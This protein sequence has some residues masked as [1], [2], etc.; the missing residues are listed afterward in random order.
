VGGA[1]WNVARA[2]STLGVPAAFAGAVSQ[3]DLGDELATSTEQAG[4]DLRF[5]QR[6]A[7]PPFLAL[8]PSLHP[9]RYFF[10]GGDSADLAFEPERL[11]EG[12]FAAAE[13][14]HFGSISLVRKPLADK[15]LR[16]ARQASAAGKRITFDPNWRN[17]MDEAYQP[18]FRHMVGL[19]SDIKVSDEDLSHLLPGLTSE[20]ALATL[21]DWNP[22]LN[23]LYTEGAKGMR[24]ISTER[25]LDQPASAVNVADTVGAGD[26]SMA[27]WIAATQDDR[28]SE[29]A[30]AFAAAS[31]ACACSHAGAH[32]P[33]L[34][35][36]QLLMAKSA[37]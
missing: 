8:V 31:A 25:Q 23:I 26:A 12:W 7:K 32:S 37:L 6:V 1:C 18:I 10:A 13:V 20:A 3:D 35:E 2:L 17:L 4:L 34:A 33:T 9:P 24:L 27:G 11:P 30:L 28:P 16:L 22:H 36:V 29:Q 19:A 5:L 14:L 15:L 21:L